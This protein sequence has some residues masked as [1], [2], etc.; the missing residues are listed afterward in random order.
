MK[1]YA[2]IVAGGSGSRM[3]SSLPKQFLP[4]K[5]KPVLFR[6]LSVFYHFDP[7]IEII[8][9]LP[10]TQIPYWNELISS[11]QEKIPHQIV[12]GGKTRFHSVK[13]ALQKITEEGIVF[14][15]DGVRPLVSPETLMR[16]LNLTIEKGN[17]IPVLPSNESLRRIE[18]DSSVAVDRSQYVMVQTPQVFHSSIILEAYNQKFSPLFTDDASVV[19][20]LGYPIHLTEGNRENI[21]ITHPSDLIIAEAFMKD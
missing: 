8:L 14:I 18:K 13:N 17:A 19:E 4:L 1:R 2:L 11:Q 5:G 10:D 12:P 21:K 6:T 7:E 15:H 16:C 20:K 9:A 3:G